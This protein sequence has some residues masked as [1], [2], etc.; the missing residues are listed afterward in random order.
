MLLSKDT[1]SFCEYPSQDANIRPEM[2]TYARFSVVSG[3]KVKSASLDSVSIL[4]QQYQVV[5]VAG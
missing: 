2:I 5:G 3:A 4:R 1:F